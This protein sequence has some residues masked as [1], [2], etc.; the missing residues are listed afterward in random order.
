MEVIECYDVGG[1]QIRGAIFK[2]GKELFSKII[3]TNKSDFISQIEKLSE[4]FDKYG[5]SKVVSIGVPGPVVDGV[6]LSA[7]PL[8]V[9]KQLD[10]KSKLEKIL[11][12]KVFVEN[13]LNLAVKAELHYGYG[14]IYKNFYLLT[15]STGIGSGIVLNGKPIQGTSGEFGHN[16]LNVNAKDICICGRYGCWTAYSSGGGIENRYYRSTGKKSSCDKIF[17][18]S[19]KE[20]VAKKVVSDARLYNAAGIGTMINAFQVDAIVIMGSL[21]LSQYSKIIPTEYET[22]K[23]TINK[24]PKIIPTKLGDKIGVLGAYIHGMECLRISET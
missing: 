18:L 1:T 10:I 14:R 7:P 12:K 4:E 15:L 11:D 23:F 5:R 19:S 13:D 24:I 9:K 8:G 21:G 2:N 16:V 20:E 6:V 17:A 3:A 22:K